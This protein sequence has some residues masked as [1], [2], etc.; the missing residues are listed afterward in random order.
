MAVEAAM[1]L[2]LLLLLF[3]AMMGTMLNLAARLTVESVADRTVMILRSTGGRRAGE[4][5]G[6]AREAVQ[7]YYAGSGL[8][9]SLKEIAVVKE[10]HWF[11]DKIRLEIVTEFS[12]WGKKTMTVSRSGYLVKNAALC[13]Q[14]G[15]LWEIGEELPVIG[16]VIERYKE[17]LRNLRRKMAG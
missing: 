12:L 13:R 15:L 1:L 10:G 17:V 4:W 2:P 16:D 9:L 7:G 8:A 5:T 6:I 14:A 3:F 11:Y